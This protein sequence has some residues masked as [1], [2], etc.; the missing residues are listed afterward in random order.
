[1]AS[2]L[3]VNELQAATGSEITI[4]VG[5]SL[6]GGTNVFKITGGLAGQSLIT[7]GAGNISF[8]A[9]IPSVTGQSGKFLTTDG[10]VTSW[11]T[12]DALPSQ[13]GQAGEFLQTDGT[14]A[15]WEAVDALPSQTG[16]AGEYLQTDG[17]TATWEPVASGGAAY[18][19]ATTSTGYFDLPAGT[20]AQRPGTPATGNFRQNTTDDVLEWYTGSTY[21]WRQFAGANPTITGI[22]PTT[23]HTTGTTIT[24]A[25]INFQ[26]GSVVKLIGNDSTV[27]TAAST[28]YISSTEVSFV[29]PVLPVANEPYDVKLILPAGGFYILADA[30]DAGGVPT[31]TTVAGSL[32]TLNSHATGTHY[33]LVASDPD[34]AAVTYSADTANTAILLTAGLTLNSDGTITGDPTDVINPTVYS[35]DAIAT[36]SGG[37]TTTRSFSI[38][39][40]DPAGNA[41]YITPGSFTWTVPVGVIKAHVVCIGAGGCSGLGNSGQAGGGGALTWKNDITV[42]P[43]SDATIVVGASA[44]SPA[45]NM[46]VAGEDSTFTFGAHVTTA[47]GG[48]GGFGDATENAGTGGGAG[49]IYDGDSYDGGGNGGVGGTDPNNHGGPGGGGAGGYSGA[50]GAGASPTGGGSTESGGNGAGGGGG[51]GGKGGTSEQ[52][53]GGGGGVGIYGEGSNG[54]GGQGHATGTPGV[55]GQGGSSGADAG[56][57]SAAHGGQAGIYGGG[58]GGPQGGGN[59]GSGKSGAVRIIWGSGRNFPSNAPLI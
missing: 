42:V 23:A 2:K 3:L 25:G 11:D 29:T 4:A 20:T 40:A 43:G 24:V 34:G 44:T 22:T 5:T 36:D 48:Q 32:G 12:V 51:G 27:Y 19:T 10:T 54:T 13:T 57:G 15:T 47:G 28:S 38:T 53:G 8:G 41:E 14:T 59:F 50:G 31:W 49:G 9:A 58:G 16:Q 33:T 45:G 39:L 30:L 1:M 21:G 46:G 52:G 56:N 6:T 26:V 55:G 17:T 18:D 37:N 35:F 7:D